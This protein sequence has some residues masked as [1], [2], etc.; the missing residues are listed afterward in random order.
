MDYAIFFFCCGNRI[1]G[2]KKGAAT[3][4][5]FHSDLI[6]KSMEAEKFIVKRGAFILTSE[7]DKERYPTGSFFSFIFVAQR[8]SSIQYLSPSFSWS[9]ESSYLGF[10]GMTTRQTTAAAAKLTQPA[11]GKAA[12]EPVQ[13]QAPAPAKGKD[14]TKAKTN[15]KG[16]AQQ[17][18]SSDSEG[19]V[20]LSPQASKQQGKQGVQGSSKNHSSAELTRKLLKSLAKDIDGSSDSEDDNKKGGRGKSQKARNA[21]INNEE[22]SDDDSV[23]ERARLREKESR[24]EK[25]KERVKA[26]SRSRSRSPEAKKRRRDDSED[27]GRSK[28][29]SINGL[30]FFPLLLLLLLL[31]LINLNFCVTLQSSSRWRISARCAWTTGRSSDRRREATGPSEFSLTASFFSLAYLSLFALSMYLFLF[32]LLLPF[33]CQTEKKKRKDFTKSFPE[34][35]LPRVF[36][37]FLFLFFRDFKSLSSRFTHPS[38]NAS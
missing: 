37:F 2:E 36:F 9:L 23:K 38:Q 8:R 10:E 11:K 25:G 3:Q 19:E 7:V 35:K 4:L 32:V 18:S 1:S 13:K 5:F 14:N 26:R 34:S 6:Y 15:T 33:V 30:F 27:N 31:L 22:L 29:K 20:E 12:P 16:K 24:R 28:S 17:S 21:I